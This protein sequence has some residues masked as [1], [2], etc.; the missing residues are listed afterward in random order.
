MTTMI[1]S[2]TV[3][4]QEFMFVLAERAREKNRYSLSRKECLWVSNKNSN[5][6]IWWRPNTRNEAV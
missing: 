5:R 4:L 6:L 1:C 3:S 2:V